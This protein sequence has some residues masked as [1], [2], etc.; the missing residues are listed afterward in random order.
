MQLG[1]VYDRRDGKGASETGYGD[2]LNN[3]KSF[4]MKGKMKLKILI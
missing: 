3:N 1:K 4:L 2:V